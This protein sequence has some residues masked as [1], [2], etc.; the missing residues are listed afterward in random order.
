M[1]IYG[2]T[3]IQ[4]KPS[5][6]KSMELAEIVD[7]RAG[8]R[9]GFFISNKYEKFIENIIKEIEKEE[10][11]NKLKRLK[12]HQDIEFLEAGIDDGL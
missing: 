9:L 10:K 4:N 7:K 12:K 1:R 8:K 2:I 11:I 6:L 5:L 3:E